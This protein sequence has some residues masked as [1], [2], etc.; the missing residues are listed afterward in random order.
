MKC[1]FVSKLGENTMDGNL[2]R[3]H[4]IGSTPDMLS[5]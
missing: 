1:G 5:Y 2:Q 4:D 3:A